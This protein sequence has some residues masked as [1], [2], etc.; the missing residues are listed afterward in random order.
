M[1]TF[2]SLPAASLLAMGIGLGTPVHAQQKPHSHGSVAL[3]VAIDNQSITIMMEAPLDNFLG[4]ERAPRTDAERKQ[5]DALVARLNAAESLFVPDPGSG[6]TV[7][8]VTLQSQALG[9][10]TAKSGT[11]AS[12]KAGKQTAHDEE[13]ADI[14][15]TFVFACTGPKQ[16]RYIDV[17]LFGAFK[18][19]RS[20][21]VQ[22]AT[23]DGQ[24]KRKLTRSASR[25]SWGK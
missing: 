16:A 1:Y 9:L 7:S 13:H 14:D 24:F 2:L 8:Q 25:L 17:A 11:P 6:C 20:I 3:D 12:S 5:V 23:G 15:A 4:F 18:R 21:D 22:L 10:G 19:I